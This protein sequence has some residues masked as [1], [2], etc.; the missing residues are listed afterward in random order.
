MSGA[1]FG[2]P[3]EPDASASAELAALRVQLAVLQRE[4]AQ[5]PVAAVAPQPPERR[6]VASPPER[7]T[8]LKLVTSYSS[9]LPPAPEPEPKPEPEP[10]PEAEHDADE[11]EEDP[12]VKEPE[13][14]VDFQSERAWPADPLSPT[15]ALEAVLAAVEA[16]EPEPEP[17]PDP[18]PD[19]EPEPEPEPKEDA[20]ELELLQLLYADL[21]GVLAPATSYADTLG[22]YGDTLGSY[23]ASDPVAE[24]EPELELE[25]VEE[26]VPDK[27][28]VEAWP[29]HATDEPE[30]EEEES[31]QELEPEPEEQAD[32]ADFEDPPSPARRS[33]DKIYSDHQREKLADVDQLVGKY[34]EESLLRM[35]RKK[36]GYIAVEF[37]QPG[38]LGIKFGEIQPSG[39]VEILEVTPSTQA[40]AK[41]PLRAGLM[42]T[43]V[44]DEPVEGLMYREVIGLIKDGGRPLTLTFRASEGIAVTF[45]EPESLGLKFTPNKQ[46]GNVEVLAI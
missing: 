43:A 16:E 39:R 6:L 24:P 32:W 10:E 18:D 37:T 20:P 22:S 7:P 15:S 23:T 11:Q 29:E 46:T 36:F 3:R 5:R 40:A 41:R 44:G 26:A 8:R 1:N 35:V 21:P 14:A 9:T 12:T 34:G 13:D 17:E 4:R 33:I 28:A 30:E 42:L 2:L 27:P 19:P 25:Q 38:T 31:E 45:T